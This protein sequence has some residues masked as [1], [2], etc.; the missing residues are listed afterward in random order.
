M[1]VQEET[2]FFDLPRGAAYDAEDLTF[3][4][5]LLD[6]ILADLRERDAGLTD[7]AT[8][9]DLEARLAAAL[10][11]CA[12][13]GRRDGLRMKRLALERVAASDARP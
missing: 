1:S 8:A 7:P 6:E 9:K 3:L 11:D 5:S 10:F 2:T 12:W 13:P 4:R